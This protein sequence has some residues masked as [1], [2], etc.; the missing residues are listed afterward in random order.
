M[1]YDDYLKYAKANGKG[2]YIHPKA[3]SRVAKFSEGEEEW[4]FILTSA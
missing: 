3:Y 4:S 2:S 1:K